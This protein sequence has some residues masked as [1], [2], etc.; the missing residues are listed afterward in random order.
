MEKLKI[1]LDNC[2][3]NRPY[4]DQTYLLTKLETEAKLFIQKEIIDGNI[5]LI[6]SFI[7]HFENNS[8]PYADIREQIMLWENIAEKVVIYSADI[9]QKAKEIMTL[10]IKEK[11]ALHLACAVFA[12]ANCFL[13]T[14][15][16]LLNKNFRETEILN[17]I[18]FVRRYYSENE[19]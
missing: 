7:L 10:K 5:E 16:K 6:W 2:C 13:T 14:D 8:N 9:L 4:D 1:Y 15:K 19:N 3:F 11:D 18:D 12:K 17:P